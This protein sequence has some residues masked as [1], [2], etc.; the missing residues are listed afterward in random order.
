MEQ[1]DEKKEEIHWEPVAKDDPEKHQEL[2]PTMKRIM[3]YHKNYIKFWRIKNGI[4][5]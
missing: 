3:E 2:S 1:K 4:D 5:R